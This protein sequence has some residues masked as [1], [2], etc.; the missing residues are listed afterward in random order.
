MQPGPFLTTCEQLVSQKTL[1]M[2]FFFKS[3]NSSRIFFRGKGPSLN[4]SCKLFRKTTKNFKWQ[5]LDPAGQ[6]Q[7]LLHM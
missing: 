5:D 1:Q 2:Q 6:I 7:N 3:Q 4:R